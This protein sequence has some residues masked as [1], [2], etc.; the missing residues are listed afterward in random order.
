MK[1]KNFVKIDGEYIPTSELTEE[2]M[3]QI[4]MKL[5]DR[6]AEKLGYKRECSGA[7]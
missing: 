4:S 2:Q 1:I 7:V 5:L 3:K 6:F